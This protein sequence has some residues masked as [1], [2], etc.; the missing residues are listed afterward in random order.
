MGSVV[1]FH[2]EKH[3]IFLVN[4]IIKLTQ[5]SEF[6]KDREAYIW[7]KYDEG[8]RDWLNKNTASWKLVLNVRGSCY[9]DNNLADGRGTYMKI[10]IHF[11]FDNE[12]DAKKFIMLCESDGKIQQVN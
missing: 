10:A 5:W 12:N 11:E 4:D 3:R 9:I 2:R 8:L 6:N 1:P 7:A